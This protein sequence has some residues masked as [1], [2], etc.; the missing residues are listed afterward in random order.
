MTRTRSCNKI[1]P[2]WYLRLLETPDLSMFNSIL[3]VGCV[4]QHHIHA[5]LSTDCQENTL[6]V[7]DSGSNAVV[8]LPANMV[9]PRAVPWQHLVV[10]LKFETVFTLGCMLSR[11]KIHCILAYSMLF[12]LHPIL[13]R[14]RQLLL[15]FIL[16]HKLAMTGVLQRPLAV[17]WLHPFLGE[18]RHQGLVM[19]CRCS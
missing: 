13:C 2:H 3:S 1:E 8:S 7:A 6:F 14:A 19:F 9:N 4:C 11:Q 5:A 10:F 15:C 12:S 18:K 16:F 17:A